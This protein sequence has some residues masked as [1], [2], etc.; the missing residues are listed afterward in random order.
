MPFQELLPVILNYCGNAG[1]SRQ[2]NHDCP[3]PEAGNAHWPN[4]SLGSFGDRDLA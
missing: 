1:I 4:G 2:K 3:T